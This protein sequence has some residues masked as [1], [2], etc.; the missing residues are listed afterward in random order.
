VIFVAVFFSVLTVLTLLPLRRFQCTFIRIA[1]SAAGSFGLVLSIGIMANIPAWSN[2]WERLWVSD[3]LAW[4]T[5][6]EKGLSVGFCLFLGVGTACDWFLKRRFGENP[7]QVN[8]ISTSYLRK[9]S[10]N[11]A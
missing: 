5:A 7:D 1:M 6:K 10:I 4:G 2:V 9:L 8:F 3:S 11:G